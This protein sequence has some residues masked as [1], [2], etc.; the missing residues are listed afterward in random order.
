MYFPAPVAIWAATF[1]I[2]TEVHKVPLQWQGLKAL[3][4]LGELWYT[5]HAGINVSR[6]MCNMRLCINRRELVPMLRDTCAEL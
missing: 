4:A 1:G 6:R 5:A 3:K 2:S